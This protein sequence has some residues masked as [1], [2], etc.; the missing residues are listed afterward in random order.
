[1][2][3]DCLKLTKIL[4]AWVAAAVFAGGASAFAQ[5]YDPSRFEITVLATG[6][7]RPMELAV[8]GDGAIYYIELDG[9]VKVVDPKTG[10]IDDVGQLKVT[11][12]QENGL[13]GIALDPQ[14]AEN[15]WIYLQYSPPDY[16]GQHISRFTLIDGKLDMASEKL[17]F[18]FEEQ[19]KE[20]CHH[21]GSMQFGRNGELFIGTGDNTHPHGDSGG[22]APID[23]REGK[24][25]WD[26]QK[27]AANSRSGSG[28]ILRIKPTPEGGYEVPE[29][30]LFPRDGS[31]GLPEIYVMGCRN[32]WR[33]S[34]DPTNNF[35][36]WGEVG[37]DAGGDGPRGPRGYDEINQA[38]KA[39]NFGWPYF[40]ANN[41]PYADYD[42]V[43]GKVGEKFNVA[44]PANDSPNNTGAKTLPPAQPAFIYYPYGG[45]EAFPEL[46]SG[47]RTACAGPTYYFDEK[48]AS[49][50]KFP[51]AFDRT[52]LI[53]E[54]TRHWIKAVHLDADYNIA[55]I[56][57]FMPQQ[58]FVRPIDMQFG[59]EGS[60]Y[61]IEYGE[62]WGVNQDARLIRIDYAAG[63]RKPIA[64]ASAQNNIGREPLAVKLSASGTSDKDA[65][66]VLKYQWRAIRAG[67]EK[68]EP[69]LLSS[70]AEPTV[71]FDKPGIYNVELVVTDPQGA[72]SAASVPVVVGNAAPVVKFLSPARGEFFDPDQPL[73]YR[74]YVKDTEDGTSDADEADDGGIE[75]IDAE[76]PS[77]VT[78]SAAVVEG[79][80][81]L[82]LEQSDDTSTPHGLRLMQKSDCFNCHAVDQKRVGPPLV[83]VAA[84][85]RGVDGALEASLKRVKEGSTGAWGKIPMIPHSQHTDDE[86][87]EMVSWVYTLQPNGGLRSFQ[88]F[89]GEIPAAEEKKP[90]V[91]MVLEVNYRDRGV[92]EIPAITTSE[93]IVLRNRLVEAEDADEIKGPQTLGSG[94][95]HGG[96]FLG[97]I[98]N[99]H[100]AKFSRVPL[101]RV[102]ALKLS[103]A[104]AGAGGSIEVR[105]DKP[106]AAPIATVPIE[107]NGEWEKF[108]E[109]TV[110][111]PKQEGEHDV[112]IVFAHPGN[113]GGLMNLDT[114]YFV[115]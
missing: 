37:P 99:G 34:V 98:N 21:A 89:N 18:K 23:E 12:E 6:L 97:A 52:L 87:R 115:P 75:F 93:K 66:D 96:R 35:V 103:V 38:R 36:Y 56:E 109:K 79:P 42:Y 63:N 91:H 47:G 70:E 10:K 68:A 15:R 29:G 1:M 2:P 114:V 76:A 20:C 111:L 65:S 113:A 78:V 17:L 105:L 95:A 94:N 101:D 81:R 86:I 44:A 48:L 82:G 73:S 60:L 22:Y 55:K 50:T 104:S 8:A 112:Y 49:A 19:R 16:I 33:L 43:T 88:G 54:W 28:K 90:N 5:D 30:N 67:E 11:T 83:D 31:Q 80:V 3:T 14:F 45:S 102:S 100:Y 110:A 59:P 107:V 26:A 77:R 9:K 57:P 108:Y 41:Q 74:V 58:K 61:V 84:K 46:G 62:S 53:Y 13:I 72:T 64:R 40:I 92:G 39:G 7:Q 71:T 25:P 27:S 85:Y 32:P 106:D 51:K 24:A 69:Q 4:C